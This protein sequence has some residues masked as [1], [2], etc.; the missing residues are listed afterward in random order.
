MHSIKFYQHRWSP[1]L[2]VNPN[3]PN[4]IH[5]SLT[6][7]FSLPHSPAHARCKEKMQRQTVRREEPGKCILTDMRYP[8]LQS[9]LL[10]MHSCILFSVKAP[11]SSWLAGQLSGFQDAQLSRRRLCCMEEGPQRLQLVKGKQESR[12]ATISWSQWQLK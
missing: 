9:R 12:L 6:C 7:I 1:L 5:I 8:F 3:S 11:P 2:R 4:C 10:K